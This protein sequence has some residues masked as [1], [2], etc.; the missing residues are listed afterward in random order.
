MHALA[1]IDG[2]RCFFG[3]ILRRDMRG[4]FSIY[5]LLLLWRAGIVLREGYACYSDT[6]IDRRGRL[7]RSR[8]HLHFKNG[9]D[10]QQYSMMMRFLAR[11]KWTIRD[12]IFRDN[13]KIARVRNERA[14]L[15]AS[16]SV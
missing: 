15:H 12:V 14:A 8:A 10:S 9:E 3:G 16:D 11:V 13:Y 4:A 7:I 1:F 5:L 2:F 6:C